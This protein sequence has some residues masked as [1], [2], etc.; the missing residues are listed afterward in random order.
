[1]VLPVADNALFADQC[2]GQFLTFELEPGADG[3][4]KREV[5]VTWRRCSM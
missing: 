5:F 2:D 4:V 1:M 3:D